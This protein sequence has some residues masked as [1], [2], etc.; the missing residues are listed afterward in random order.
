MH[1]FDETAGK[2]RTILIECPSMCG[3]YDGRNSRESTD[4]CTKYACLRAIYMKNMRSFGAYDV[5][6]LT[7]STQFSQEGYVANEVVYACDPYPI[8]LEFGGKRTIAAKR[9]HRLEAL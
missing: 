9:D 6:E 5:P 8:L 4:R 7:G 2:K 3:K 1:G